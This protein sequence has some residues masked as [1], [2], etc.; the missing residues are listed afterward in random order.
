MADRVRHDDRAEVA[1]DRRAELA[2]GALADHAHAHVGR[3]GGLV[4]ALARDRV[5]DV[6]DGGDARE[7]LDLGAVEALGVAGAVDALVVVAHD[8]DRDRREVGGAQ[9]LDAGV[10]VGLHDRHLVAGQAAGL[11]EDLG[12]DGELADVVHQQAEAELA[13]PLLQ[14][15]V[16]AAAAEVGPAVGRPRAARDQQAEHASPGRCAGACSRRRR[17]GRPAPA[18][19]R[20]SPGGRRPSRRR[21]R[22]ATRRSRSA[23]PEP[24]RSAAPAAVSAAPVALWTLA[25]VSTDSGSAM[26]ISAPRSSSIQ[27]DP[28]P[29]LGSSSA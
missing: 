19:R 22:S 6:G 29:A 12:R 3:R 8:G 9:E 25:R 10:R 2:A 18:R 17:R 23:C 13:Q 24:E 16:A 4:D 15:V 21:R 14:P 20:G 28:T 27:T 11:V 26:S 7:L 5:V 1:D